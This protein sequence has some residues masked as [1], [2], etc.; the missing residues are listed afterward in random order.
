MCF[1]LNYNPTTFKLLKW[2]RD[3]HTYKHIH[4][5][6][7]CGL[8]SEKLHGRSDFLGAC[9]TVDCEQMICWC[10][11][12]SYHCTLITYFQV[13]LLHRVFHGI[14]GWGCWGTADDFAS[15]MTIHRLIQWVPEADVVSPS[16]W[17][18]LR[19]PEAGSIHFCYN[20]LCKA[21]F[22][23]L[24]V[25]EGGDSRCLVPVVASW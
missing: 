25:A 23:K 13:G 9:Q 17:G 2:E 3:I 10:R 14:L 7:F 15:H 6:E 19:M 21:C 16:G 12:E 18:W 24:S 5:V 8:L 11:F 22:E 4:Q 20:S 1:L